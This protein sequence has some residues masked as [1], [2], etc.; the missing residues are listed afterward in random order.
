MKSNSVCSILAWAAFLGWPGA[1]EMG[2]A[3][4]KGRAEHVVLIVWDGMRPDFITPQY[5]PTLYSVAAEGVFFRRHHPVFISTT[6]VNGAAL[7]TGMYPGL[8]GIL[9]NA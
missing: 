9:A 1:M 7:A 8:N 5:C 3:A 4:P 6:E 2:A